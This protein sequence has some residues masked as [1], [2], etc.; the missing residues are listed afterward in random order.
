MKGQAG[1]SSFQSFTRHF[2]RTL[3]QKSLTQ[4]PANYFHIFNMPSHVAMILALAGMPLL[5]AGPTALSPAIPMK[6]QARECLFPEPTRQ[7]CYNRDGA[8]PQDL[9]PK[10]VDFAARYLRSYQ[11]TAVAEGGSPFWRMPV[12]DADGCAE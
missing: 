3:G 6:L 9:N 5:Q 10:E 12:K 7:I 4:P 1:H 11:A 2:P 8:T